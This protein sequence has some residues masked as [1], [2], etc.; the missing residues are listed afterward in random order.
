MKD[1][2]WG[3]WGRKGATLS[4]KTAQEEFG[5]TRDEI[6]RAIKAGKTQYRETPIYGNPALRLLRREVE[7]LAKRQLGPEYVR[8]RQVATELTRINR[9]LRRLKIQMAALEKRPAEL[10]AAQPAPREP[11]RR[12]EPRYR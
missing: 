9:E 12:R 11:G 5:L 3:E 8:D 7:V 4:D 2:E 10:M 6:V 1:G